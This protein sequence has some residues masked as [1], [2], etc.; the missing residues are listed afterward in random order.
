MAFCYSGHAQENRLSK[1]DSLFSHL[2]KQ[3]PG[4]AVTI[5]QNDSILYTQGYGMANLAYNVP[6]TENTLI[7]IGSCA[8]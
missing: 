3:T 4:A 6:M 7:D 2:N 8:N 5:V 1:V